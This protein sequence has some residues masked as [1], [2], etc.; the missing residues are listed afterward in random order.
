MTLEEACNAVRLYVEAKEFGSSNQMGGWSWLDRL[1]DCLADIRAELTEAAQDDGKWAA[2]LD[3]T[4]A[5]QSNLVVDAGGG[6]TTSYVSLGHSLDGYSFGAIIWTHK[7]TEREIEAAYAAGFPHS[8]GNLNY[9]IHKANPA[10]Q[11]HVKGKALGDLEEVRKAVFGDVGDEPNV[12]ADY[13][14]CSELSGKMRRAIA[15]LATE[16]KNNE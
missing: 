14:R 10:P 12:Y 11:T 2:Y 13:D 6:D 16:G 9:T 15:A 4:P 1:D 7:P 8:K 3:M 5:P